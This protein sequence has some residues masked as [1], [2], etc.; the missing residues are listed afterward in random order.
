MLIKFDKPLLQA[1]YDTVIKRAD[2]SCEKCKVKASLKIVKTSDGDLNY[3]NVSAL[4][5]EC[6]DS[7]LDVERIEEVEIPISKQKRFTFGGAN[8]YI[9]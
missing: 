8:V 1:I 6:Y 9:N 7:Y 3:D 2:G 5:V 4:C